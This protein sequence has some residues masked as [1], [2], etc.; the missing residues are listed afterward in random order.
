MARNVYQVL[1]EL[2]NRQRDGYYTRRNNAKFIV[3]HV[4]WLPHIKKRNEMSTEKS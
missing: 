4:S 1:E 3:I 2:K